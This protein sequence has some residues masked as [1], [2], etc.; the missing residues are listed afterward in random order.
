MG[1]SPSILAEEQVGE[2]GPEGTGSV[3]V[4]EWPLTSG[5]VAAE[6][7]MG[8]GHEVDMAQVGGMGSPHAQV[9]MCLH[10]LPQMMTEHESSMNLC[11]SC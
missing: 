8:P 1:R 7:P 5:Q 2:W 11:A 4:H 10:Q 3:G 9:L 6:L